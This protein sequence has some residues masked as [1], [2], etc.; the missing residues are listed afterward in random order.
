MKSTLQKLY[1]F[2]KLEAEHSYDNRAV[3]G[4]LERMLAPW[5]P[6]ARLEGLPEELIHAVASRLRDYGRLSQA[7]RRESLDGLWKRIQREAGEPIPDLTLPLPLPERPDSVVSKDRSNLKQVSVAPPSARQPAAVAEAAASE[8]AVAETAAPAPARS[9]T[10]E[11]PPAAARTPTEGG[12]TVA[13]APRRHPPAPETPA[14]ALNAPL[15]V[16]SGVGPKHA[17]TLARLGLKSLGDM[18]YNFPRRYDDYSKLKPIRQLWY[19]EVVTVIGVVKSVNTRDMRGGRA[20]MVEAIVSDGSGSLRAIWWNPYEAKRIHQ[21]MQVAL[22]GKVEQ[23]LGR[24]VMSNPELEELDQQNLSTNRIVPIYPLTSHITQRWL[25]R[26][27]YQVVSYWAP[28]MQDILPEA[29][30]SAAGVMPLHQAI[31]QAHFPDSLDQLQSARQRL[32]FDE[33]FLLQLGVLRQKRQWQD[34]TARR[35]EVSDDWLAAQVSRLPFPLTGAQQRSL[36]DLRADLATGR[37]MNRLLQGDVGSGKTVIAALTAAITVR[38]ST[39]GGLTGAGAQAA[40]MAP[41][42]ILAEQ[43][44]RNLIG[45]L[46]DVLPADSIRLMIGSTPES[47]KGEIRSGLESGAIKLVVGTHALIE[48]PVAFADLQ[49]VVIDEQHRF[50]VEQRAILRSKGQNPHLLV[51]TATPI[52]RSLALTVYGDLDLSVMDE[53]PPGRQPVETQVF[54]PRERERAYT[55]LRSQI[56]KGYQAFIIYPLVEEPLPGERQ[57]KEAGRSAVEEHTRLQKEVFPKYRLGLLH[58]RL[59]P[60][61]K[62]AV[63]GEFRD[64]KLDILISTSVVEVGVDVPNA[65]VMIIEG[66]DRFGLAQLHQFRGRVGRSPAQSYCIL[67]PETPDAVENA[68]LMAMTQTTDG[69]KLAELDLSQRGP[70][71]FL[72]TRQAGFSELRMASLTDVRLIEKAR[73]HAQELFERDADLQQPEHARLVSALNRFWGMEQGDIS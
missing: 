65:T 18:L 25:R 2:F 9:A 27:I 35:F 28:R 42:S 54:F 49:L 58:G 56:D 13:P 63:M 11:N 37:P 24:L 29:V 23:Y 38:T 69:F 22:S 62:D 45:L 16:L 59:K 5:E 15:T 70:G 39:E 3:I 17:S 6:E 20:R 52:P 53:M 10:P 51:M 60:D 67:I 64:R 8:A 55:L 61:E 26:L 43:H 57:E 7:S 12:L 14:A 66:A 73:R 19:G 33:I 71:D 50:G 68:R 31:L 46:A 34:R 44:H 21:D 47:E 1:K 36:A 4:G 41:T 32:A 30:R 40:I 72:G 48:D